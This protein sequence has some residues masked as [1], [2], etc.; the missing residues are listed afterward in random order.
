MRSR[1]C[2]NGAILIISLWILVI[3]SMLA[4][5]I[6]HKLSLEI[7]LLHNHLDS[8]KA[9]YIAKAGVLRAISERSK[10]LQKQEPIYADSFNQPW[11]NNEDLFKDVQLGDGGYMVQNPAAADIFGMADEQAK[12]NINT[13]NASQ[14]VLKNLLNGIGM[15]DTQAQALA[16]AIISRRS[17]PEHPG[18]DAIEELLLVEGMPQEIF[19]GLKKYITIY[20]SGII[21]INTSDEIVLRAVLVKELADYVL[22][23]RQ[24]EGW[25][26]DAE[27]YYNENPEQIKN[28]GT[29]SLDSPLQESL[30][31]SLS[32]LRV[33][34]TDGKINAV[35]D[36]FRINSTGM[37]NRMKRVVEAVVRFQ[38]DGKYK[39]LFWRQS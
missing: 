14:E 31:P 26:V 21:N 10:L 6:G 15:E 33:L 4:I 13:D 5:G 34:R 7:R 27:N 18:F 30:G 9:F 17:D 35:S 23:I 20:G 16:A 19:D 38:D 25:F 3:L 11:L 24:D 39:F 29:D 2:E 1:R 37:V 22:R 12:I 32:A 36:T 28:I 8:V